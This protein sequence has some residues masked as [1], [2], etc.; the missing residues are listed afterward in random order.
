MDEPRHWQK[1]YAAA[2]LE[3][4]SKHLRLRIEK[5]DEAI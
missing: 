3:S 4:D 1:L 2:M 5:A